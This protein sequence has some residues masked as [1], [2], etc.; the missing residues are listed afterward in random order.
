[1]TFDCNTCK[2]DIFRQPFDANAGNWEA[3]EDNR[4]FYDCHL[5]VTGTPNCLGLAKRVGNNAL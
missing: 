3:A 2:L 4:K 1:M 5:D